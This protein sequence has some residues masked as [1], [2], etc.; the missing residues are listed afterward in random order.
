MNHDPRDPLGVPMSLLHDWV[1]HQKPAKPGADYCQRYWWEDDCWL[2]D[3]IGAERKMNKEFA[4]HGHPPCIIRK[5][6][7]RYAAFTRESKAFR[8]GGSVDSAR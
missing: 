5:V 1:T 6:N 7:G 3:T 4:K 8:R 2:W